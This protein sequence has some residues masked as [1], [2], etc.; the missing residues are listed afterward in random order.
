M[1]LKP[2]EGSGGSS[3]LDD[4]SLR[5]L[6]HYKYVP[7]TG[8]W[9]TA[10]AAYPVITPAGNSS[11]RTLEV[12]KGAG[13]VNFHR[14]RWEDMPTQYNIV[15]GL[16]DLEVVEFR[17][18]TLTKRVG[19]KDLSDRRS[20]Q[21]PAGIYPGAEPKAEPQVP[22]QTKSSPERAE[23]KKPV[24]PPVPTTHYHGWVMNP[25]P[26]DYPA[27]PPNGLPTPMDQTLTPAP[28]GTLRSSGV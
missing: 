5:G 22:H 12:R 13:K 3:E 18:A 20:P 28:A 9:G 27:S 24:I 1:D 15:N 8:E 17:G 7:R 26:M 6:M 19:G 25:R 11:A 21:A 14:A 23:G 4:G 2:I 10:D 16:A